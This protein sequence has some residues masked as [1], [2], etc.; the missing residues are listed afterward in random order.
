MIFGQQRDKMDAPRRSLL[1]PFPIPCVST[2]RRA[3]VQHSTVRVSDSAP[4]G[5]ARNLTRG[6]SDGATQKVG[7]KQHTSC[8]L[9]HFE[10]LLLQ[11]LAGQRERENQA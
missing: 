9:S 5:S 10:L 11:R 6:E 1:S 8:A 3:R 7:E 4:L 2:Q